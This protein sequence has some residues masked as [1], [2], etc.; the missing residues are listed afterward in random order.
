MERMIGRRV[1]LWNGLS[2]FLTEEGF[3][4][5]LRAASEPRIEQPPTRCSV[6]AHPLVEQIDSLLLD[7]GESLRA[8]E[9][10]TMDRGRRVSHMALQRHRNHRLALR[11]TVQPEPAS[12]PGKRAE[13][14]SDA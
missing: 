10:W 3:G 14:G 2:K 5:L 6:C 9:A 11:Q 1:S 13:T 4:D 8:V 7:Q 12:D